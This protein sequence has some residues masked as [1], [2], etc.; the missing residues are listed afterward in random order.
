MILPGNKPFHKSYFTVL[1]T[2]L[3]RIIV[4]LLSLKEVLLELN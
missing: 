2:N 1:K 4:F 3:V